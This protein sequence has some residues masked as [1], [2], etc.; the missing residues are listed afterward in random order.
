MA[1]HGL[2]DAGFQQA[3][4]LCHT[5]FPALGDSLKDIRSN[6]SSFISEFYRVIDDS[7][8][9][10]A[11]MN[12]QIRQQQDQIDALSKEKSSQAARIKVLDK[13]AEELRTYIDDLRQELRDANNELNIQKEAMKYIT[14]NNPQGNR[15]ASPSSHKQ[16]FVFSMEDMSTKKPSGNNNKDK[17]KES[18]E[19]AKQKRPASS[20]AANPVPGK[21]KYAFT[22]HPATWL[23]NFRSEM[24]MAIDTGKCRE[25]SINE[26]KDMIEKFYESKAIANDKASK[27]I[28][29][30]PPET[31]EQHIYR[32]FEKK[33]GL[34]A[35]AVEQAGKLFVA[36]QNIHHR[37][38]DNGITIFFKI[39]K[40]EI[41]EDFRLVQQELLRSIYDLIMIQL[42]AR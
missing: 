37:N 20:D 12:D 41:E 35:L 32:I 7:Q 25:L 11:E 3:I 5:V 23:Y 13:E 15:P 17:D 4:L 19:G 1:K 30:Y 39:F 21:A 18:K 16:P 33:F 28:G 9:T 42:V 24:Q 22:R 29:S 8:H 40:N 36:V 10:F 27:G 6:H 31:M 34:R 26:C 2:F 14:T 38:D